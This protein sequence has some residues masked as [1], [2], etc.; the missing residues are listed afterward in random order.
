[1]NIKA[2]GMLLATL[3]VAGCSLFAVRGE[4]LDVVEAG[5]S[6]L[7]SAEEPS[8]RVQIFDSAAAVQQWQARTG[9]ELAV[10]GELDRG[11]YALIEMGQRHT[12]GY[13]VA[14]SREARISGNTL[15]LY[16]TF[17]EPDA[18][19]ITSQMINSPCALVYL[20]EGAYIG[21]QVYDQ[22]GQL[23]ADSMRSGEAVP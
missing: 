17:F 9:I 21:V 5:R 20:P 6:I 2:W 8:A 22:H 15:R 7:C 11:R 14:V 4:R 12:G 23:R 19:A 16:A 3:G 13:G 10:F 18:G 1:M